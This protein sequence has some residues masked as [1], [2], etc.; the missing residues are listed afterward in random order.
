[1]E[2]A[3][4][5]EGALA[6]AGAV[7][8]NLQLRFQPYTSRWDTA[9]HPPESSVNVPDWYWDTGAAWITA[10]PYARNEP[11][12]NDPLYLQH[13]G[14]FIR[15]FA[16]RYDGHPLFESVGVPYA[17]FWG[18]SG[19]NASNATAAS[20]VDVYLEQFRRTHLLGLLL[21]PGCAHAAKRHP[22]LGCRCRSSA[23]GPSTP[24]AISTTTAARRSTAPTSSPCA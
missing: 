24:S 23:A 7:G 2:G 9:K 17:D 4:T 15:A 3:G 18:E 13:F 11:N 14:D 20:L 10:G 19:G 1:M 8:Q 22:R 12:S 16:A 21:S 5:G 6:T